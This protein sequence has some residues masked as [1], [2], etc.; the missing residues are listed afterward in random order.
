MS[1]SGPRSPFISFPVVTGWMPNSRSATS[2]ANWLF[3]AQ[4]ASFRES[5]S[6]ERSRNDRSEIEK[7][8]KWEKTE[9]NPYQVWMPFH[10][11]VLVFAQSVSLVMDNVCRKPSHRTV[12][13][14]DKLIYDASHLANTFSFTSIRNGKIYDRKC[15][16][17]D[18]IA[19][20]NHD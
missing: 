1:L 4:S 15:E 6:L 3:L 8:I 20:V 13:W 10:C 7:Q 17:Y 19:D 14:L 11:S 18:V 5:K 16:N 2:N 12:W 9:T